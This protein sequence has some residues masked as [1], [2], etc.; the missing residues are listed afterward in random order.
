MKFIKSFVLSAFLLGTVGIGL[1][2]QVA[3]ENRVVEGLKGRA[4]FLQQATGAVG[5]HLSGNG[6]YVF[7]NF[8][9]NEAA[10]IYNITTG[11]MKMYT[12]HGIV[13][14][15][16]TNNYVATSFIMRNNSR[17]AFDLSG[18]SWVGNDEKD[19]G[20]SLASTDLNF[21]GYD[22][23]I[24]ENYVTVFFDGEGNKVDT[25][26][27]Y[28]PSLGTGYGSFAFAMSED[29]QV[30]VGRTS[31]ERA[32][33]NF[34]AGIWD[35]TID[36]TFAV[37]DT[38]RS[39]DVVVA[40]RANGTLYGINKEG[41][42]ATGELNDI[43]YYINYDK[44]T[45]TY[46][47]H[48][49]PF[50]TGYGQGFGNTIVGDWIMG[51][52]QTEVTERMPWLYNIKTGEKVSLQDHLVYRYGLNV[53]PVFHLFT[54]MGMSDDMRT[55][56]GY[57]YEGGNWI[58]YVILLD[59]NQIHPMPRN[60]SVRQL[61][62][63]ENVE[64]QWV[65]PISSD[66]YTLKEY[67]IFRDSVQIGT[68]PPGT[69]V[70]TDN[71]APQ[72]VHNYQVAAVYTDEEVSDYS[73]VNRIMVVAVGGCLPVQKIDA[74]IEYNRTVHLSWGLPSANISNA[75]G[76]ARIERK[77]ESRVALAQGGNS[78]KSG[79]AA[80]YM[81]EG[82]LDYVSMLNLE[83]VMS[84]TALRLDH[85]MLVGDF[86]S[87]TIKVFDQVTG[88]LVATHEVAKGPG[89]IFD[90]TY[91]DN[92]LYCVNNTNT[93]Y[94]L[95]LTHFLDSITVGNQ[96]TAK[97]KL[98]HIC[99]LE[100]LNEGEDMIMTGNYSSLYF[101]NPNPA[102]ANDTV[103]GVVNRFD[104]SKLTVIGSAYHNG[105]IY[106]S[107]QDDGNSSK[108]ETYDW[109]SGKHL[110]T[111][112][113]LDI[114][115]LAAE[116]DVAHGYS[117]LAS[118]ITIGELEDGTVVLD[119]VVQPL[120]T[121]NHLVTVEIESS[122]DVRGYNVYRD[123]E[124]INGDSVLKARHYDDVVFEPGKYTYTV[125]YVAT[126][127]CSLKSD[128]Y[129][130]ATAEIFEI[131][132]CKGPRS[133]EA[134]ESN[135]MACLTWDLPSEGNDFIGFNVYRDGLQLVDKE[136]TVHFYDEN[137]E[138]GKEY[139]YRVEAFWGN[140]CVASDSVK[141]RPTFEGFA[142]APSGINVT[143][144]AA[145]SKFNTT[146][147]WNL[148]FF[149]KPLSFGYCSE[150][151][152]ATTFESPSNTLYVVA[153][154]KSKDIEAYKD[155]YLVGVEFATGADNVNFNG[156]VYVD[157]KLVWSEP[158]GRVQKQVWNQMFFT[159]QF[160]MNQKDEIAVG[161]MVSYDPNTMNGDIVAYDMGPVAKSGASDLVSPD[162]VTFYTMGISANACIRALVV[163]QR[164]LDQAS[165]MENGMEYL[166]TKVFA[167][168]TLPST[169]PSPLSVSKSTSEPYTLKGFNVYRDNTKL[170]DS[171][172]RTFSFED[173]GLDIGEYEYVVS[174]V[175][176]NDEV[177]SEPIIFAVVANEGSESVCPVSFQPNPVQDVLYIQGEYASLSLIDMSGR[178]V[179]SDVRNAQSL[180]MANLQSGIY[181]V[182][183]TLANG[184]S[185]V[186][187]IVKK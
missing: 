109:E 96:W 140:S 105:R 114:P 168:E 82:Q 31:M 134:F 174:A 126:S 176:A 160:S 73:P 45:H 120:V 42:I 89:G 186:T 153:G 99:Y 32:F 23:Y 43:S 30:V 57:S 111:T 100:G 4:V 13:Q 71:G 39:G 81:V 124:K 136:L 175:Y 94:E 187:K 155:L 41:T 79:N 144:K 127:G 87:S 180:P 108:V 145:G 178:V 56:V 179:L 54:P 14:V 34:T 50:L 110:F 129:A 165:K 102:D 119:A 69:L 123:G 11:K 1:Q 67:H 64:I 53:E 184:Q 47:A 159:K 143:A 66:E 169:E 98:T 48:E 46:E 101:Y 52:D 133:L 9:E 72:G 166:K 139:T 91:H 185:Y 77:A 128:D 26:A 104:V 138:K 177:K 24:G 5:A 16:D 59:E 35:R 74:D 10:Y 40:G 106:F 7:G 131:G 152:N 44:T 80:K 55:I 118:G 29:K 150:P 113:L 36:K 27:H 12:G 117:A 122:P 83:S 125:E 19:Y 146:T 112:N 76:A 167:L 121:Y 3:T 93:V 22:I 103:A 86:R 61:Y 49:I 182:R 164:D 15:I 154:W 28:D 115:D 18:L 181:F 162:G 20:A 151:I 88:A 107:N 183:I 2:A 8:G 70:Y 38:I 68:V 170:N 21:I 33:S 6:Q 141:I 92:T 25:M 78:A 163:R 90:M 95:D 172:L 37:T 97:S 116:V 137:V 135:E 149:E 51:V 147:T 17:T 156:I 157:N 130:S 171:V 148:P 161:Y 75:K 142:D 65:A 63:Q 173:A 132:E 58:P 158:A 62:R 60:V 85:Y 84:S